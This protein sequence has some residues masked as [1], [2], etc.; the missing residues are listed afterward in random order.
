MAQIIYSLIGIV[1]RDAPLKGADKIGDETEFE[2]EQRT[3][4]REFLELYSKS[5][6]LVNKLEQKFNE[7]QITSI[8]EVE[9]QRLELVEMTPEIQRKHDYKLQ[10]EREK[11]NNLKQL[12]HECTDR[13]LFNKEKRND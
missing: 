2:K 1:Q 7:F 5:F 3:S 11:L 10:M 4:A 8:E 9:N 12:F 6:D 13:I